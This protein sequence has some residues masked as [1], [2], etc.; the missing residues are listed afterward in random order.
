MQFAV[1]FFEEDGW[2][3]AYTP[4]FDR[5]TQGKTLD[6]AR[7]MAADLLLI[8]VEDELKKGRTVE[9]Q[10]V[11]PEGHEWVEIPARALLASQIARQR[12]AAGL[13]MKQLAER[14]GVTTGTYQKWE[15]ARRCNA[16]VDTL[17]RL[18]KA[19]GK[20]LKISFE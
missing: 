2:W 16:G 14:L 1:K 5:F 15:S 3:M 6:E 17:E 10:E 13:T 7:H 18:A 12:V 20:H 9:S 8:H 4:R 11:L 19:Y